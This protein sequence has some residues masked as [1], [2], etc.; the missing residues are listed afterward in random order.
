MAETLEV[1][2][3]ATDKA[4]DKIGAVSKSTTGLTS[5]FTALVPG[6]SKTTGAIE[7]LAGKFSALAPNLGMSTEAVAG[8]STKLLALAGPVAAVVAVVGTAILAFT[9]LAK[10]ISAALAEAEAAQKVEVQLETQ[11][12]ATGGAAGLSAEQIKAMATEMSQLTGVEDD[13]IIASANVLLRFTEISKDVFPKAQQAALDLSTAMGTDLSTASLMLGKALQDPEQGM[14]ALR[15]AGIMFDEQM[16]KGMASMVEHGQGARAQGI[17]LSEVAKLVGGS[18][19]AMGGTVAGETAKIKNLFGEM[20]E[21]F[22]GIL[23][24]LKGDFLVVIR[25]IL[26]TVSRNLEPAFAAARQQVKLLQQAFRDPETKKAIDEL[27]KA[28]AQ[29][30]SEAAIGAI[31][32]M[33]NAVRNMAQNWRTGG[34]AMIKDITALVDKLVYLAETFNMITRAAGIFNDR[35]RIS[36]GQKVPGYASG[37]TNAPGGWAMVGES[38][39]ELMQVPRGANIYPNGSAP[40]AAMGGMKIYGPISVTAPNDGSLSALMHS[41]EAAATATA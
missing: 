9:G 30:F 13:N 31:N 19:E 18:A 35:M 28:V 33:T 16:I 11:I 27:I 41:L 20:A 40:S 39:P 34:P 36:Q 4:S 23:L 12:K 32:I 8:M 38:G 3:T 6:A 10:A 5:A 25:E 15:R 21:S 2:I 7:G 24:P 14:T 1:I 29:L 22:G 17:I 37:V 26:T